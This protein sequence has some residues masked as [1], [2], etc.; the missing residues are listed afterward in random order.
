MESRRFTF[1]TAWWCEDHLSSE[2]CGYEENSFWVRRNG[3]QASHLSTESWLFEDTDI[4]AIISKN[5]LGLLDQELCS[6]DGTVDDSLATTELGNQISFKDLRAHDHD[7]NSIDC[8]GNP[9][10]RSLV[11]IHAKSNERTNS[12]ADGVEGPLV[13]DKLSSPIAQWIGGNLGASFTLAF[14]FSSA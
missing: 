3:N 9:C 10:A 2:H 11:N 1:D 13:S 7:E 5:I 6:Y 8:S 4:P 12:A 14:S